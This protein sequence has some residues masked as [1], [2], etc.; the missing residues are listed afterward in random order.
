MLQ[1][2]RGSTVSDQRAAGKRDL[3]REKSGQLVSGREDVRRW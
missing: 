3:E 2:Y 1:G